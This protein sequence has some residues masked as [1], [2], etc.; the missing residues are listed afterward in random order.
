MKLVNLLCS[1]LTLSACSI[2]PG[3][4][5]AEARDAS[6]DRANRHSTPSV[7]S[8]YRFGVAVSPHIVLW[9]DSS[10]DARPEDLLGSILIQETPESKAELFVGSVPCKTSRDRQVEPKIIDQS[11]FSKSQVGQLGVLDSFAASL[12]SDSR[13]SVT[14]TRTGVFRVHDTESY[15]KAT[16]DVMASP[17]FEPYLRKCHAVRRVDGVTQL[18]VVYKRFYGSGSNVSGTALVLRLGDRQY[19]QSD[20]F[21]LLTVFVLSTKTLEP[22]LVR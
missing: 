11:V 15:L 6:E 1:F 12:D 19:E 20:E 17:R 21:R 14:V 7:A 10:F 22:L 9:S 4:L 16:S 2:S 5:S 18:A 8:E 3:S 13:Y